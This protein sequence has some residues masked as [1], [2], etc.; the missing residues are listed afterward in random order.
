[1]FTNGSNEV[2]RIALGTTVSQF[3]D[4]R[5]KHR[6]A[7]NGNDASPHISSCWKL[8]LSEILQSSYKLLR[9]F[10]REIELQPSRT[11]T[12]PMVGCAVTSVHPVTRIVTTSRRRAF[13]HLSF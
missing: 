11:L 2:V 5:Q 3:A 10:K 13:W 7:G 1:M 9:M 6:A 8:T 12:L 4:T